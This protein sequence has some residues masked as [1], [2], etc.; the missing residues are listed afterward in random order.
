MLLVRAD[1]LKLRRR[2]GLL[3][4]TGLLTVGVISI[5]YG[6]FELLALA[7]SNNS[8]PRGGTASLDRST[9]IIGL[10]GAVAAAVVG[11][12]AGA[13]DLDA[14]VYRD[15]VVTGR[16]RRQLFAARIPAGLTILLPFVVVAYAV[17]ATVA[18]TV[19][20][21]R[22][23]PG[24]GVVVETGLWLLL[25]VTFYYLLSVGLAC[26]LASRT[27]TIASLLAFTLALTP[28]LSAVGLL[29]KSRVAI[30]AV[31]LRNL[32]PHGLRKLLESGSPVNVSAFLAAVVL[33]AWA[34]LFGLGGGRRDERRDA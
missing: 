34:L 13:G 33:V 30:P 28:L 23:A 11:A 7:N 25:S 22:P 27:Y 24:V 16:S 4:L 32:A 15:L 20:G 3:V 29:G 5:L 21:P 19:A 14:R 31:A 10:L 2:R 8:G 18:T 6:A 26:V 9:F 1:I 17:A 12:T